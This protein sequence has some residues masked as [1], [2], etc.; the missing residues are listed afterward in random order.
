MTKNL[1]IDKKSGKIQVFTQIFCIFIS[2]LFS[3]P[4]FSEIN[5]S[6]SFN[7]HI[8]DSS[9]S[10]DLEF[11]SVS[12]KNDKN[13]YFALT[14]EKGHVNIRGVVPGSYLL[15]LSY[16]GY[17]PTK[18]TISL[19][20]NRALEVGLKPDHTQLDAVVITASE[21]KKM[22]ASSK[23]DLKAMQHL[24]PSSFTDLLELL[25]GGMSKDPQLNQANL[26]K[27]R[28]A[29]SSDAKYDISSLG[30][31]FVVDGIPIA[32]AA[33][34]QYTSGTQIHNTVSVGKG[35][36]MRTIST[37]QIE[38]VEIVRGIPSVE[39]GDLTSGLINIKRKQGKSPWEARFKADGFSKLI[40]LGKGFNF[41]KKRLSINTGIDLLDAQNDPRDP[42]LNYKRFTAS[43]RV[44][45]LLENE[46]YKLRWNVNLD[47]TGSFDN[48]KRDPEISVTNDY[49]KS[50][51]NK[52]SLS[53]SLAWEMKDNRFFKSF[54]LS[55]A[56]NYQSDQIKECR[57]IQVSKTSFIPDGDF[58]GEHDAIFLPSKYTSDLL[59]DGKPVDTF[60]KA[61]GRFNLRT[62]KVLNDIK[63]GGDW[64]FDKN[65]GNGQVYDVSR[66]PGT[67]ITTRP[68][69][70]KDIPA[71]QILS[72]FAEDAI[73][74]PV[75]NHMVKFLAGIRAQSLLGLGSEFKMNGQVYVDPRLNAQWIFPAFTINNKKMEIALTGGIGY[76]TKFPVLLQ[77]YPD[78][79]YYDYV[80]LNYFHTNP[81]LRR[82][83]IVTY[84]NERHNY[85]LAPAR[86]KKWEIGL[87]LNFNRN[88]LTV[89]Y[90]NEALSSGFRTTSLW[91]Q[92]TY[93]EYDYSEINPN[94]LTGPPDLENMPYVVDTVL[95]TYGIINNGTELIKQGIE[96]QFTTQRIPCLKTRIT[97]NGAW[98][99]TTYKNSEPIL[100]KT[101]TVLNGKEL[102]YIGIYEADDGYIKEQF[103]TNCMFDTYIPEIGFE[104]S[105][106]IQSMWFT[107]NNQVQKPQ[108]PLA[109][110]DIKGE[111]HPYTEVDKKDPELQWL[112]LNSTFI[113]S[114]VPIALNVNFKASKDFNNK[115]RLSVFVNRLLDY[116]PDYKTAG[117]GIVRRVS[118]PYFGMELNFKL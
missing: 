76:H 12:L 18:E 72:M 68:R 40:Y 104:F 44:Q 106:S 4:V 26:I 27:L 5:N 96:Y 110:I 83:N 2:L 49:F 28:E 118:N 38:S 47:Y 80:Q 50:E 52:I 73:V 53:N 37:D 33:E 85:D 75:N 1:T 77:L 103:N 86:N 79:F 6:I 20:Q 65:Y 39:Y 55:G 108:T 90:F 35:V 51:Y 91:N 64:K 117:G 116:L 97:I 81:D 61:M 15:S 74:V 105:T 25:P 71:G 8:F 16:I 101:T 95:R 54:E 31:S 67:E 29:G 98:F 114:K 48:Q 34:M 88:R 111:E 3:F 82:V 78:P 100:K 42:Y 99:R 13:E 57:F 115:I 9:T 46:N 84:K 109:Y 23:I 107:S 41:D 60:L 66:P 17:K 70:Y 43:A 56:I 69:A 19:T 87:D 94:T 24:Q 45:K 7:L 11:V 92:Y 102:Q 59:V 10:S 89:T 63:V 112:N 36:D 30:T 22:T 62:G 58:T 93:K 113:N 21:S 32:T 14:D